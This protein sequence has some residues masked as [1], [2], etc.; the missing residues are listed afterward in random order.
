[1]SYVIR[2]KPGLSTERGWLVE[3]NRAVPSFLT[4]GGVYETTGKMHA[5][6][7]RTKSEATEKALLVTMRV[8]EYLG[9]LSV[10]WV[11]SC[12]S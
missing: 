2:A 7:Y 6:T 10:Q 4:E 9:K 11:P 8:P 3:D 12:G 1:M 5:T